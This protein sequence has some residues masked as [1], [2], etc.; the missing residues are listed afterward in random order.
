MNNTEEDL[1]N[2]ISKKS[3]E[4]KELQEDLQKFIDEK[5]SKLK[6]LLNKDDENEKN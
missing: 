4:L 2:A 1:K 3:S 6:D 5:Q